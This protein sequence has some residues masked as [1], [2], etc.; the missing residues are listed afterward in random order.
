M[1]VLN[2]ENYEW[3]YEDEEQEDIPSMDV[4][5]SHLCILFYYRK[6]GGLIYDYALDGI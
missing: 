3:K 2:P 4:W 5:S 1:D 6:S